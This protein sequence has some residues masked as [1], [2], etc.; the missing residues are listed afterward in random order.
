MK[1]NKSFVKEVN[2]ERLIAIAD[3]TTA[4][5]ADYNT[6]YL[7]AMECKLDSNCARKEL[8]LTIRVV[9]YQNFM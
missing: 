2:F 6:P 7:I 9:Q 5:P 8:S 4:I 3:K 1:P